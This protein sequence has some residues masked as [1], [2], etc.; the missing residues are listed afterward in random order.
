MNARSN[1]LRDNDIRY[2]LHSQT[3]PQALDANGPLIM[4]KGEGAYVTDSNGRRYLDVLAGLWCASLGFSNQ[5]IAKAAQAAYENLAFYHSFGGRASPAAIEAAAAI[6][7]LVPIP[8]AHIFFAT[9]GSEAIETM[10]KLAW[11]HFRALGQ[12]S[13]R[14]IIARNRAFHGSTIFA[15]SLT[16]LPHMHREFGLPLEGIVHV[17]APDPY[18]GKFEN[19]SDA[20]FVARL[21]NELEEVILREGADTIAA[22]IAE[23][24][25]AGGGVVIPPDGYFPAMQAVLRKYG[26]LFLV[27]E[28]VCGFGR[29]GQWFGSQTFGIEPDMMGMA[30]GLSSSY[31]PISAV[32]IAPAIHDTICK[33]NAGGTNFGHGFTNSAHPVGS[34]IV[35]EVLASYRDMDVLSRVNSLGNRLLRRLTEAVG[36]I[37]IVGDIRGKGLLCGVEIVADRASKAP[38][39]PEK[40]V[41]QAI[42]VMAMEHELMLRPQGNVIAFCPPFIITEAQVDEMAE[43]LGVVLRQAQDRFCR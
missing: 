14:K 21:A 10:V 36:D 9:S 42:E 39:A 17:S 5:R 4:T 27:D 35:L 32:A 29:T 28:V 43:K 16:G 30:K 12:M 11:L 33:A 7:A 22:F 20:E 1:S 8:D 40:R 3:N 23:P 37:D 31:F 26:I 19:E 25:N 41:P 34:A 6:A 24:V 38:F 15:A 2:H 13:R 18:R